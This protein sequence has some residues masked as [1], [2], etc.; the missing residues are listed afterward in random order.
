MARAQV[1]TEVNEDS[2]EKLYKIYTG[3]DLTR[4]P[5]EVKKREHQD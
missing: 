3:C 2:T 5:G 4:I 1:R